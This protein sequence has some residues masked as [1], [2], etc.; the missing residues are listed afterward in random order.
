MD[1]LNESNLIVDLGCHGIAFLER[2][3][4][5]YEVSGLDPSPRLLQPGE[6]LCRKLRRTV[7]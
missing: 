4:S 3:G 6:Y 7:L 1:T 2:Y 5:D